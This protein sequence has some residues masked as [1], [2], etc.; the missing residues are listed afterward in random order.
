M[1]KI[2]I[3]L[4][5][6]VMVSSVAAQTEFLP[7]VSKNSFSTF[8]FNDA[9]TGVNLV[10]VT[11]E[12]REKVG[13]ISLE[14]TDRTGNPGIIPAPTLQGKVYRYLDLTPSILLRE[15]LDNAVIHFRIPKNVFGESDD[16]ESVTLRTYEGVW[17]TL[18]TKKV[19]ETTNFYYYTAVAGRLGR[20]AIVIGHDCF[21]S[22]KCSDWSAC[23][24]DNTQARL[25]YDIN[26]CE[27]I[28]EKP[29]EQQSCQYKPFITA[30]VIGY[31]DE[32]LD[33]WKG[34]LVV[35]LFVGGVVLTVWH[36][37]RRKN[38]LRIWRK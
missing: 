14:L 26:D 6:L 37:D 18:P 31:T 21:E 34:M 15:R 5:F 33:Y 20:A 9:V 16:S 25:C 30:N 38:T 4:I 10:D 36:H 1:K 12:N 22:W 23:S 29:E 17:D 32:D 2:V 27:S 35:F 24:T 8:E 19:R 7:G 13:V 11:I 3:A 28:N